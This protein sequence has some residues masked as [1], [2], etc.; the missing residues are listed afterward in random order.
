MLPAE[1]DVISRFLGHFETGRL[2]WRE[3]FEYKISAIGRKTTLGGR[4]IPTD[5]KTP[6]MDPMVSTK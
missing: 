2:T 4:E 6:E 5:G 3:M 1:E